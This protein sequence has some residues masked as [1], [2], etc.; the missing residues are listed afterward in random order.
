MLFVVERLSERSEDLAHKRQR[1]NTGLNIR[2]A[3]LA[4]RR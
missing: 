1:L 2:A 4:R 3:G